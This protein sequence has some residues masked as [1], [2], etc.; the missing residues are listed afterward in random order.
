MRFVLSMRS[1]ASLGPMAVATSVE[2]CR[3]YLRVC[4]I[5]VS[6]WERGNWSMR[7]LRLLPKL[8]H[9]HCDMGEVE[10]WAKKA[11]FLLVDLTLGQAL[12]K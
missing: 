1:C 8:F 6:R 5:C 11:N 7:C 3:C 4:F 9:G 10:D 2:D 12:S